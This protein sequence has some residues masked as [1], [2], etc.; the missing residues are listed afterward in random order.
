MIIS[1]SIKQLF[2]GVGG[3]N[4]TMRDAVSK[5]V[6]LDCFFEMS[7]ENCQRGTD[8]LFDEFYIALVERIKNAHLDLV[9]YFSSVR[10]SYIIYSWDLLSKMIST[11]AQISTANS[12]YNGT[13]I[14][15]ANRTIII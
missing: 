3:L 14:E 1:D 12:R 5:A 9:E 4:S 10:L 8:E 15:I 13:P 2:S 7:I 6:H 11:K